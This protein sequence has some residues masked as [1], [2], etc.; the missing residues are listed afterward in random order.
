[1]TIKKQKEVGTNPTQCNHDTQFEITNHIIRTPAEE[2][3]LTSTEKHILVTLSSWFNKD[4]KGLFSCWVSYQSVVQSTGCGRS[5]VQRAIATLEKLN[6]IHSEQRYD[7]SK[8]YTWLGLD[9]TKTIE[10]LRFETA[11]AEKKER[12]KVLQQ[13]RGE[14]LGRNTQ[15]IKRIQRYIQTLRDN[16]HIQDVQNQEVVLSIVKQALSNNVYFKDY[17]P[18]LEHRRQSFI[19]SQKPNYRDE[20]DE[21]PF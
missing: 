12:Q 3:S 19:A 7:N 15:E 20:E 11:T 9:K 21:F 4:D 10:V 2:L 5:T 14:N 17:P 8:V 6:Y 18:Y 13:I 1:M 16:G